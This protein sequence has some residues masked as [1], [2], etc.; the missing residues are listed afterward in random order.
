MNVES[1]LKDIV[2]SVK[3]KEEHS[4]HEDLRAK[5]ALMYASRIG[6]IEIVRLLVEK[7]AT[8]R[9]QDKE[10]WEPLMFAA[11][12]GHTKVV[13]FLI[14]NGADVNCAADDG[15]TALMMAYDTNSETV[16]TLIEAGAY[17]DSMNK[18]GET[19]L[20]YALKKKDKVMAQILIEAGAGVN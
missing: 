11:Q 14:E 6:D 1:M 10:G 17:L 3:V 15:E 7:G 8:V 19:A 16:K 2:E 4:G 9:V 13:K 5:T 20:T 18:D 12:M